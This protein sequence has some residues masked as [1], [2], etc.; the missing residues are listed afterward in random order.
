MPGGRP[1]KYSEELIEK[2][3]GYLDT[4]DKDGSVIPTQAGLALH[5]GISLACL[6]QWANDP[7][8]KEFI[9]IL[10]KVELI[11]QNL[12]L[13]KGISGEFNSNITKLV[14]GKHGFKEKTENENKHS[15]TI[16]LNKSDE[17]L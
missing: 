5:C 14:L 11:Q 16:V 6:K 1:S 15:H 3:P 17:D 4:W 8:K 10:D 12:L 7:D 9:A 13:N 2:A